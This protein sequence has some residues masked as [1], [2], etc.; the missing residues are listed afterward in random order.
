V[1]RSIVD[2]FSIFGMQP[3]ATIAEEPA[4]VITRAEQAAHTRMAALTRSASDVHHQVAVQHRSAGASSELP[5]VVMLRCTDCATGRVPPPVIQFRWANI[6]QSTRA[7]Q[8]TRRIV[9]LRG[10]L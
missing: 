9:D 7:A 8:G 1:S 3:E 10:T 2:V 4:G 5:P 6:R